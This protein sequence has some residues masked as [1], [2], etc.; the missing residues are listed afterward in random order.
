MPYSASSKLGERYLIDCPADVAPAFVKRLSMFVMRSD[1]S[2]TLM[3]SERVSIGVFGETAA[4]LLERHG[5]GAPEA[6]TYS[7]Q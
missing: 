3:D 6:N 1:V 7:R 4:E 5:A 2:I